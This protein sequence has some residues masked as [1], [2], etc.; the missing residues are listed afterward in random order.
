VATGWRNGAMFPAIWEWG[1]RGPLALIQVLPER[2][3]DITALGDST[4]QLRSFSAGVS[5]RSLHVS[6]TDFEDEPRP[7]STLMPMP[8]INLEEWSIAPWAKLV[9]SVGEATAEG[10][11]FTAADIVSGD[12]REDAAA[13]VSAQAAISASE[14]VARFRAAASQPAK[15]LAGYL[16][17]APL[18]LPV[19]RLV[20]KALM[21]KVRQVDLAEVLLGGLVEQV[22]PPEQVGRS[23]DVFY[24]FFPEVRGLLQDSVKESDQLRVIRAVSR[25]IETQT[26]STID[27]EALLAGS[28]MEGDQQGLHPLG[29]KFA[30]VATTVLHRMRW[31]IPPRSIPATHSKIQTEPTIA[32]QA[33]KFSS[34]DQVLWAITKSKAYNKSS[35]G[36]SQPASLLIFK[37][38]TQQTWLVA[39]AA[40]LYIVLDTPAKSYLKVQW[41]IAKRHLVNDRS[42][43]VRIV[44]TKRTG[45]AG[46]VQIG[47]SRQWFFS[48]QLFPEDTLGRRIEELILSMM[49]GEQSVIIVQRFLTANVPGVV[50]ACA[51]LAN[52]HKN[53]TLDPRPIPPDLTAVLLQGQLI[54]GD[55]DIGW[56]FV[57]GVVELLSQQLLRGIRILW[58]DDIPAN[59][60]AESTYFGGLGADIAIALTTRQAISSLR[61]NSFDLVLSDM[62]RGKNEP[63][64]GLDLL[65]QMRNAARLQPVIIYANRWARTE[66][67]RAL[68]A[69]AFGCTNQSREL[70]D[71][72][73]RAVSSIDAAPNAMDK[74]SA[75]VAN[76][77]PPAETDSLFKNV[78]VIR[79]FA[80]SNQ[81]ICR[82]IAWCPDGLYM[83]AADDGGAILIW[84]IRTERLLRSMTGHSRVVY[85]VCWSP[86]GEK[87]A[88]GS[89]DGSVRV[90]NRRSGAV[91]RTLLSGNDS[92]LGV[93]W[94]ATG[95]HIACGTDNGSVLIY[96]ADSGEP[97]VRSATHRGSVHSV[98][99]SPDGRYL[100]SGSSDGAIRI[101]DI[102]D[103]A[104]SEEE[105]SHDGQVYGIA[106]SPDGSVLASCGS[107]R[108]IKLWQHQ[109]RLITE[110]V[111]HED[112]VTDICFSAD[113][114]Y[115]ASTSWDDTVRIWGARDRN[116]LAT[117]ATT[118]GRRFHAGIAF[119]PFAGYALAFTTDQS[120]VVEI[121]APT[122]A[123][124]IPF[125]SK[126]EPHSAELSGN[127]GVA[128]E[129][130]QPASVLINPLGVLVVGTGWG[131]LPDLVQH[132]AK[133]VGAAVANSGCT[134]INGGWPGVDYLAAES[135]TE[136]L[137]RDHPR[138]MDGLVQVVEGT[139]E[140]DF[141]GG[142][143]IVHVADN[144]GSQKTLK[145][146]D[147]VILIGG[148]GGTWEAFR[149]ALSAG[150]RVIPFMNTGTDARHAAVLLEIFGENVPMDL[151]K[152]DFGNEVQAQQ[153]G[154]LLQ[155]VLADLRAWGVPSSMD[156]RKLLWMTD[157]IL[158]LADAY[159]RKDDGYEA[160][161][162]LI[163]QQFKSYGL[164]SVEYEQLV[165]A[166]MG[167]TTPAWR[168][169][170]YIAIEASPDKRFV[171]R[172][173]GHLTIEVALAL[174][175]R[176]SRPL[177]RWLEALH[178]LADAW[179]ES[180]TSDLSGRLENAARTIKARPQ[181]DPG[182]ECKNS[183]Y[184]IIRKLRTTQ[185]GE[186]R[187]SPG[188]AALPAG[189]ELEAEAMI[190]PALQ[191]KGLTA[192]SWFERGLAATNPDEAIGYYNE[193]VRLQPDFAVAFYNRGVARQEKGD[194]Y[195][196]LQDYDEAINLSPYD[197][198]A[199]MNRGVAREVAG[200]Q[201][202][203]LQ[204]YDKAIRLSPGYADAFM[205]RGAVREEKGDLDGAL[206][207]YDKAVRLAPDSAEIFYNRGIAHVK[208]GDL[209]RAAQD[210]DRAIRLKPGYADAIYNR[211]VV[212]HER[213]EWDR[214]LEDYNETIR[215]L[216]ND[217]A[218]YYNRAQIW[219]EKGDYKMAIIDYQDYLRLGGGA[220]DGDQAQV[221]EKI[222]S[223]RRTRWWKR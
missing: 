37:T 91:E 127:D 139:K 106:W 22:T 173:V 78:E 185:T 192:Q 74:R 152:A 132:A 189:R 137:G 213:G 206:Q 135:F 34:L 187:V 191:K 88:S 39:T 70:F 96:Q 112:N 61:D 201:D 186:S 21:S 8:V 141:K 194:W 178:R 211:G 179:P 77:A 38:S 90:W 120:A 174:D 89:G 163:Y 84:D 146:A 15:E 47:S 58:V 171:T 176:E 32:K 182:G 160:E 199:F 149:N 80:D 40:R 117:V 55:P 93:A 158:P 170:A 125:G 164:S 36:S 109:H 116:L 16:S 130:V 29:Q 188:E 57:A 217:T 114:K 33:I 136:I 82:R 119:H 129:G 75:V 172:L 105:F 45:R 161:A 54:K 175:R 159:L 102:S 195:G 31:S 5:N 26:G 193:A 13:S 27:F 56:D 24:E 44:I 124:E 92:A 147:I 131:P 12:R 154:N 46:L 95:T 66:C 23:E 157:T 62:Y 138:A 17:V 219:T 115:L 207:D 180:F 63:E 118:S 140:P 215:L 184:E 181:V 216:P 145:Y 100:A 7:P 10:V 99:W 3:W 165:F 190:A 52:S 87:L 203:A 212:L 14:R 86:N 198:E 111:A 218:A 28:A 128:S 76:V 19:M 223:L 48:R 183:I 43:K 101:M 30:E 9:A 148:A 108:S 71:L 53:E 110:L 133:K 222:R 204:D 35:E 42:V 41:S 85:G 94:S 144:Q 205:N 122:A 104:K 197:A 81:N 126:A 97:V 210:Y 11:V 4:K 220:H 68:D 167:D 72:V 200:D 196:A 143:K 155:S 2:L 20:Q 107:S 69:G 134:L 98:A 50:R 64:A 83:A 142:G 169:A 153:A 208:N 150:K 209:D 51:R 202:G 177:W 123:S 151:I 18:C 49:H 156:N 73:L 59:N 1:C 121:W 168:C 214:A 65:R 221:E 162:K 166:L 25:L 103:P 79:R 113:G 67:Q 6:R 60:S